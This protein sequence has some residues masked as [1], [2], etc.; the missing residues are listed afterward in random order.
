LALV[1][2]LVLLDDTAV[3][4]AAAPIGRGLGIGTTGLEWVVNAYTV[5]FAA[6]TLS[7]GAL[8]DRWG[9]RP[10]LL[11]GV[12]VFTVAS[13]VATLAGVGG[14]L[15]AARAVQGGGAALIG[16]A[17]LA[18]LLDRFGGRD[19]GVALGVWSGTAAAALAGGPLLGAVLVGATMGWRTIFIINVPLG[20]LAWLLARR[21]LPSPGRDAVRGGRFDLAGVV[22]SAVA[23]FALV[24]ALTQPAGHSG[25]RLWMLLLLAAASSVAFV[26]VERRAKAPLLDLRLLRLPNFAAANVLAMLTLAIMCGLFFYLALY[27][28][29][30]TGAS[31]LQTGVTLLPLTLLS[32]GLAPVVGALAARVPVQWLITAGMGLLAAGLLILSPLDPASGAGQLQ[33]GLLLAGAGIGVVTAPITVV[34]LDLIPARRHGMG[35]AAVNTSRTIG[36]AIGIAVMGTVVAPEGAVDVATIAGRRAFAAGITAGLRLDASLAVAA[37]L[38]TMV[39][40]RATVHRAI[41]AGDSADRGGNLGPAHHVRPTPATAEAVGRVADG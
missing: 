41:D 36:L 7:G 5:T 16:P 26:L 17:A 6:C 1:W 19:R 35:S 18:A 40:I 13:S 15:I 27:L 2:F 10:V 14:I 22:T 34:A 3:T 30:A 31:A 4:I 9:P 8:A 23:M 11:A 32:A 38:I 33:G 39:F 37:M 12:A 25:A 28:Q 20:L 21:A 29:A 24:Y